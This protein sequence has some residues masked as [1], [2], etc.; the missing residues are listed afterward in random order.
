MVDL[1]A[2]LVAHTPSEP[3]GDW[4]YLDEH[5]SEVADETM[6]SAA[7]FGVAEIGFWLGLLHDLG[8]ALEGF[9]RY[10]WR[11]FVASRDETKPPQSDTPHAAPGA[12]FAEDILLRSNADG[13]LRKLMTLAIHAHHS[14][15][16]E[17]GTS[18]NELK[19]LHFQ[20]HLPNEQMWNGFRQVCLG[21]K[22]KPPKLIM[23]IVS[24]PQLE[25]LIR[26][27]LSTLV[28]ADRR[29]TER[30]DNPA[31]F[32]LR[33]RTVEAGDLGPALVTHVELMRDD[34]TTLGRIRHDVFNRCREAASAP[35]GIF[36]LTVP[37][38][39]GKTLAS[40]TFALQRLAGTDGIVVV[41]LPYTSIIEQTT[42]VYRDIPGIGPDNVL[43]HHSAT[44]ERIGKS[45]TEMH[46]RFDAAAENWDVPIVV[47]TT[48]QLLES[49]FGNRPSKIRKIHR[50]AGSVIILDEFQTLPAAL[51]VPT[52]DV[53]R[54]LAT[55]VAEG[56][57]GATVVLC[58]ATQPSLDAP[59]L[60]D[61]LDGV[62]IVE[63]VPNYSEHFAALKR[64]EYHW[65]SEV[66]S[67][68]DLAH[69]V[70]RHASALVIVNTRRDALAL[71]GELR[72]T[73]HLYH[74]STLLCG[75]HRQKV[76]FEIRGKLEQRLPVTLVS[77]QVV[78]CG[79]DI[80]FPVV[81]RAVGPLDRIVQAAGR[82]NRNYDYAE[83]GE[84]FI[85][86]PAEGSAPRGLYRDATEKTLFVM[87]GQDPDV[88]HDP[89]FHRRY[90]HKLYND[91]D[92]DEFRIQALREQLNFPRISEEYRLIR[93]PT[94]PVV[95]RYGDAW[96]PAL[97]AH[98]TRPSRAS[99]SA[100]QPYIVNLFDYDIRRAGSTIV[101]VSDS[102]YR[103]DV[104]YHELLGIDLGDGVYDP[105]DLFVG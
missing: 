55:P 92:L 19:G 20:Q 63:I 50:L 59:A 75:A 28:D 18:R 7:R 9:Q 81:Y 86:T 56:G 65:Q 97:N 79:V 42:R 23:P 67:W 35:G 49:L 99:W 70:R 57:Y 96:E 60:R 12:V 78:E 37:T 13:S 101:E 32:A 44:Q 87:D 46:R 88:L 93:S 48:V 85:F 1:P 31:R 41:A 6:R 26:M 54:L 2:R 21:L 43:E 3:G 11:C 33:E 45:T 25:L 69:D 84:V 29:S 74:L 90:F 95:V 16:R 38:G 91:Q 80:S 10:L 34:T 36:R 72:G 61:I 17:P 68:A 15:L 4:H 62:E 103:S 30:H 89:D 105:S 5:S 66:V 8:K 22:T 39:G 76:L 102:L 83:G 27:L 98:L 104:D 71:L 47:T 82:C 51:L 64:V 53:L 14:Y 94:S 52:M 73:P 24:N 40:L 77:T 100:L 58:T